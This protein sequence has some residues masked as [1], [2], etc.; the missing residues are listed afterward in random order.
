MPWNSTFFAFSLIEEGLTEQFKMPQNSIYNKNLGF[1][2]L[3]NKT[4]ID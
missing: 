4:S 2:E 1:F 3:K